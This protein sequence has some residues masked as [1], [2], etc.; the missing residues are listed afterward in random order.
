MLGNGTGLEPPARPTRVRWRIV[1][2][3]AL[4]ALL[5][6]FNRVS[7][8]VAGTEHIIGKRG[9]SE[10][11]MGSVYSAYL[12]I[13][14]ILMTP[15]G[16]WIDRR[17]PR[18]ALL[19][20]SFGSALFVALTGAV[21][22]VARSAAVL[23]WGL[24]VVR[25]LLGSVTVPMHPGAARMVSLWTPPTERSRANGSVNATALI[26][27]ALAPPGFGFLADHLGWPGAFVVGGAAS[28]V[29]GA[30][31][32][33]YAR[34]GPREHPSSN[35]EERRLVEADRAPLPGA[36]PDGPHGSGRLLGNRT[37]ILLTLSYAANN[38]FQYLFV[39]WIQYYFDSVLH[40]GKG[41]SRGYTTLAMLAMAAGMAS[42]GWISDRTEILL[43][44]RRGRALISI[45]SMTLSALFLG[46][47]IL[48]QGTAWIVAC[49]ALAMGVLG[50]CEAAFWTSAT[51]V[52]ERHG[53]MAAAIMN[54]GGNG[55]GLLAPI[56][57]P[58]FASY[59]GWK[60]G[61]G[62]A[63]GVSVIGALFWLW[64][65]PTRSSGGPEAM[66]PSRSTSAPPPGGP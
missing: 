32:M 41:Q 26:G 33:L 21:G 48:G 8:A 60:G 53:G 16:W 37:L 64:I 43:G 24:L 22:M 46:M 39:Y 42:G 13:Y 1:G 2:L 35:F 28:A 27:I 63:C 9:L 59:F 29:L 3:L 31:W 25:G 51:Q 49:F 61:L 30:I 10:T 15:G 17:G 14:T 12:L 58:L 4:F 11:Q 6:H 19:M 20:M 5:C 44:T 50:I 56:V 57:T 36:G 62:L 7:M 55:G 65:D 18:A 23:L 52:G 54:T 66:K 34:D 47:G 45:L 38:Y 40:L